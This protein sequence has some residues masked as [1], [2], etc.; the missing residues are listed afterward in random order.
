[1]ASR[2]VCQCAAT[3]AGEGYN[4]AMEDTSVSDGASLVNMD[5]SAKGSAVCANIGSGDMAE[6]DTYTKQVRF[7]FFGHID[8]LKELTSGA[9]IGCASSP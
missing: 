5:A 4:S 3:I 6:F 2:N 8:K 1:M 9:W 7:M